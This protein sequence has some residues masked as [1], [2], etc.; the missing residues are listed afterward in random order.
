MAHAL[1]AWDLDKD[2][3]ILDSYNIVVASSL[4]AS[5]QDLPAALDALY[6]STLDGGFLFLQVLSHSSTDFD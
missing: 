5:V 4:S 2:T 6:A 1:Q 3:E